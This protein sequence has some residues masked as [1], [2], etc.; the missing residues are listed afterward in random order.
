[1]TGIKVM[2]LNIILGI[3]ISLGLGFTSC[4]EDLSKK[5]ADTK[6]GVNIIPKPETLIS[7]KE[8]EILLTLK[9]DCS[10]TIRAS[11]N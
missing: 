11:M 5:Y 8:K 6:V 9:K 1:M 7:K 2:K 4:K 3:V 10:H